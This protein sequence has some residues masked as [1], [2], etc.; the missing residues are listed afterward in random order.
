MIQAVATPIAT[1]VATERLAGRVLAAAPHT[2]EHWNTWAA[3]RLGVAVGAEIENQYRET[4]LTEQDLNTAHQVNLSK[5]ARHTGA[6]VIIPSVSWTMKHWRAETRILCSAVKT[7]FDMQS[8][9][10][11]DVLDG[12]ATGSVEMHDRRASDVRFLRFR[13]FLHAG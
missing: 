5:A 11:R 1:E 12:L 6:A 2:P 7:P 8:A 3:Y 9:S 4:P 10:W 13:A